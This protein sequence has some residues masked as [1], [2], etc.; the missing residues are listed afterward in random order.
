MAEEVGGGADLADVA[1]VTDHVGGRR[2]TEA[3]RGQ[4]GH[5][6]SSHQP[7]QR[8]V[9]VPRRH[10]GARAAGHEEVV[11]NPRA[12]GREPFLSLAAAVGAEVLGSGRVD[13]DRPARPGVLAVGPRRH[14]AHLGQAALDPDGAGLEFDVAPLEAEKI[15]AAQP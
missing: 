4:P 7:L 5:A 15:G 11:V 6:G 13:R 10:D 1:G 9:E 3:V 8:L 2:V 12:A 14:T